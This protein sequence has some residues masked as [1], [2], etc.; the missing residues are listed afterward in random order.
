MRLI[1]VLAMMAVATCHVFALP[2]SH[3]AASSKLASGKWAKVQVAESGMQLISNSTLKNL[4]FSD[5]DKV[6]VYGYG[7]RM[8]PEQIN[9]ATPDDLPAIPSVRTPAGIVFFGHACVSWTAS[10]STSGYSHNL[11]PYS[12]SAYY[13]ISDIE[14]E[15]KSPAS[16]DIK[17]VG[18][19]PVTIFTERILHEQDL[20]APSNSGRILLGE[21]FRTQSTRNFNFNLPGNIG[22]ATARIMF[23]AMVSNGQSS[24]LVSANGTQL[25]AT[26]SDKIPGVGSLETFLTTTSSIKTI[27]SPGEKLNLSIKYS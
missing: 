13:F 27:P 8:L 22:D 12:Q 18:S 25:P 4:G 1:A 11:N 14:G 21:D 7:G 15:R 17:T 5:P 24:I 9:S 6:N 10:T 23:G 26:N 2:S 16:S 20:I 3:Y 19:E